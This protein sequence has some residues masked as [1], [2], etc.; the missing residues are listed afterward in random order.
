MDLINGLRLLAEV[1]AEF[2][3][4]GYMTILPLCQCLCFFKRILDSYRTVPFDRGTNLSQREK[5]TVIIMEL[6]KFTRTRQQRSLLRHFSLNRSL[7]TRLRAFHMRD[8]RIHILPYPARLQEVQ[9]D[10]P[11]LGF[12]RQT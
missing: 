1:E 12:R 2:V 5:A 3:V 10:I 4:E 11:E 6:W 8:L 7:H 9:V